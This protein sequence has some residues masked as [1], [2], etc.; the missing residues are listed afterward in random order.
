[1][2]TIC[3]R[4]SQGRSALQARYD[5]RGHN[6]EWYGHR[7]GEW[8]GS[9]KYSGPNIHEHVREHIHERRDKPDIVTLGIGTRKQ[10]GPLAGLSQQR[11]GDKPDLVTLDVGQRKNEDSLAGLS[12]NNRRQTGAAPD[13]SSAP[14]LN[15]PISRRSEGNGGPESS[16]GAGEIGSSGE[17]GG[18]GNQGGPG[19]DGR[20]GQSGC[21]AGSEGIG[22][23]GTFLAGGSGNGGDGSTEGP[24]YTGEDDG[25]DFYKRR[26]LLSF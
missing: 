13:A 18:L 20:P 22:G 25:G 9:R 19:K 15:I 17:C 3:Q 12:H 24:F 6:G 8:H 4:Y 21:N 10:S 11:R 7:N 5:R 16:V 26:N 14:L 2:Q 1:M 23:D